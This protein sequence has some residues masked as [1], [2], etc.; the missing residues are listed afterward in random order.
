MEVFANKKPKFKLRHT[1]YILISIASA[2]LFVGLLVLVFG[3]RTPTPH[4]VSIVDGHQPLDA[5]IEVH[6]DWPVS[7]EVEVTITPTV[8][9]T[10]SYGDA[11]VQDQLMRELTFTPEV[12]WLPDTTYE[13]SLKHVGSAL[14]TFDGATEYSL[15]F[16]TPSVSTV[17]AVSPTAD[18]P[19]RAD[20]S[21][22]VSLDR[23]L[24]DF[25]DMSFSLSPEMALDVAPTE[26]ELG[27]TVTPQQKLSQGTVYTL[28]ASRID[29]RYVFGTADVAVQS[30]PV[31]LFSEEYTVREAPG[32][33]SFVPLG[34][35]VALNEPI[36]VTMSENVDFEQFADYITIE[37]ALSGEW[38]TTDYKTL[39]F[40]PT[41]AKQ[42]TTYT[43]TLAAE[44]PTFDGGYLTEAS[45]HSF[46]TLGPVTIASSSPVTGS[47]GVSVNSAIR[48]TFDQAV[49]TDSAASKFS[50]S[51]AVDGAISWDGNT[52][53]FTPAAALEFN[54]TYTVTLAKGIKSV[55]GFPSDADQQVTFATELSV[56]KLN[57]AYDRQDHTLSC[58]VATLKMA[59]SYFGVSVDE[60]PLIDA[61]GFDPTP[62]SS[63]V[64][65]DPN[66][67]F[68][69]DINGRQP[70]TGYGVY[71]D[72]IA[73]AGAAY[74]TTR[75]FTGGQLGHIIGEI[76]QGHP[77][78]IWGTAGSG[79]DIDW[80][81]PDG[82]HIDAIMGEHTFVVTGY[83]GAASGPTRIIVLD[84]L[85]GER[86]LS[87][88]QF[89]WMWGLLGNSGVVV[90]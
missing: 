63:G 25:S 72:P 49:H 34:D 43:V 65:G 50:I 81:T 62:K 36:V 52:M 74:R 11:V 71:W 54:S 4:L 37:P 46:T 68:V 85:S 22:Q 28:T 32:V 3:T 58:E 13:V 64:W 90:E 20:T 79:A 89:M 9:G 76:Q 5:P 45:T 26:D 83:V 47:G 6:F 42:D 10:V 41:N 2:I 30:D 38:K 16:T 14:P 12:T 27:Y 51:P 84:P 15:T 33:E 55:D 8:F 80:Q 87:V 57:I 56:T 66:V 24:T 88:D 78:I 61:I 19:I 21:W 35:Q 44:L 23:P 17:T 73:Q 70:S 31:E 77:V 7:R 69:G 40:V 53:I 60:Q 75:A 48:I 29:R 82:K 59:L 1:H 67:A 86:Y 39:A 18:E